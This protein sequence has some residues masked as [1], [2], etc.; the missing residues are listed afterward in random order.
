MALPG[1]GYRTAVDVLCEISLRMLQQIA[2]TTLTE[3]VS[4]GSQTVTVGSTIAMYVGAQIVVDPYTNIAE[5]VTITAFVPGVSFTAVFANAHASGAQVIGATFPTQVATDALYTQS[6][7][8]GYLSRAQ[9]EFL[10]KA[11]VFYAL[12]QQN[13]TF[14]Q[15]FQNTPTNCIEINRV[16]ASTYYV[17]ITSLTRTGG[18]VTAITASPHGLVQNSSIYIQNPTTGFGGVFQVATVISPTSFTYPQDAANGS[19]TGGAILS[20]S[21]IYETTQTEI[22]MTDRTWR[23][24]SM[25]TPTAWFEDRSGLYRWGIN[26][27]ASSN[28]PCELLMS[29]R[30]TDTLSFL[31]E[32]LIPDMLVY[33]LAYKTMQYAFGKDGVMQD[34][35]RAAYCGQRFDRGVM[36][37]NRFLRGYEMNLKGAA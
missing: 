10:A 4:T 29:I 20:F 8:L 36:A 37:V 32:F 2:F 24:E 27:K 23:N 5:V 18:V 21:R 26:C 19:A 11:P 31:D 15:V 1:T 25:N 33:L 30:D 7:M 9:N 16:A 13:L 14:G 12:E 35:Q 3:S 28:F 17:Q 22:T 34:Q 6:E